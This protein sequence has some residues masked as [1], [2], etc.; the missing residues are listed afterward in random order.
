MYHPSVRDFQELA[1]RGNLIPIWREIP[2]DMETPVSVYLKLRGEWPSFLLESVEKGEQVGRYSFIGM[3]PLAILTAQ[4]EGVFLQENGLNQKLGPPE[5]NPL[6]AIREV[7]NR[8]HPA[9]MPGLPRLSGG[10]VGY[11]AYEGVRFFE[12][13]PLPERKSLALPEMVFLLT[14][15]LVIFDHVKHR[16]LLLTNAHLNTAGKPRGAYSAAVAK[17]ESLVARLHQ[18]L[19]DITLPTSTAAEHWRSN[20]TP[21]DFK[22]VVRQAKEYIAAGDI[23]QVVL[24]Q[25]LSRRTKA[26]SF[27]IYRALRMLNPS[28]YMFYLEL[29]GDLRLIGASPE[30]LVRLEGSQAQVRPIAGTRRRGASLAEDEA[31]ARELL[32]DPKERAEHVMLVDLGRNDLGRVCRYGSV[33]VPEMM[34]IERYSHVMHIVSSVEGELRPGLDACDLLQ[35]TFPA[36]TVSGAPKVRAMEIIAELEGEQRG[37]YAGAVGYFDFSGNMDTCIAIRT[38]VMQGDEVNVQAGAG[39]VADSDPGREYQETL[40]KAQALAEAVAIAEKGLISE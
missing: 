3:E 40:N 34:V 22:R 26:D 2:A 8:Y 25:R 5:Y 19:P 37:P 39:I 7:L 12:P 1:A 11:L 6:A 21:A 15:T 23:F 27:T 33:R 17:I 28:P 14:D 18:P 4:E 29:P 13:V 16:L 31:L 32:A 38:I 10:L 35:A 36:G 20:F 24:S 9:R 30:M